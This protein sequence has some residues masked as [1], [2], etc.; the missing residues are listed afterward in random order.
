MVQIIGTNSDELLLGDAKNDTINGFEGNDNLRGRSGNDRLD[1]GDG[2][3]TADYSQATRGIIA[4]LNRGIALAPIYGALSQHKIMPLGDSITAGQHGDTS[5]PG[6]YR[7]QLGEDFSADGLRVD[8][9]GS[10]SNGPSSLGDKDHEGHGGWRINQIKNLVNG[11]LLNTHKPE[12]VL[13]MIGTNDTRRSSVN[14]MYADLNNLIDTISKQS[15]DTQIL[16]SS[17]APQNPSI[18]GKT[19][20][21]KTKEFNDLIP[22]LVED[23]VAQGKK[24]SF[25]NAGGSLSLEDLS[26]DGFHPNAQGY[27]KIGDAWYEALVERDT[28][29]GIENITG[30]AF[31]DRLVGNADVNI[32]NGGA[33][34]DILT[35]GAGADIFVYSKPTEG[36]DY[37][38]DFSIDDRFNISAA[39][40]G[41]GLI[42]GTNLS[43]T[44][45][46]TGVFVSS[47]TPVSLGN[48]AN[49]LYNTNTGELSFDVDGVG[50]NSALTLVRLT[51][52]PS[53]DVSQFY[54]V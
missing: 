20:A 47:S 4:N 40:F 5:T 27:K 42:A 35:G 26:S 19:I 50:F 16:V 38:T 37:I 3:D 8:F 52:A 45:S 22:D 12:A 6:A 43:T 28:L 9:V 39:G 30:T 48:S 15:P 25:V 23:K 18:R 11:G 44:D 2:I 7:I 14:Q 36:R 21:K 13:L 24:V 46:S 51:G 33:S 29:I 10:G 31:K 41:G 1:G 32:I 17:I 49:F 54:I 53:L 34:T